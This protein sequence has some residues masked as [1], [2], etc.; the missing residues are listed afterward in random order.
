[1]VVHAQQG[2]SSE[3]YTPIPYLVAARQAMGGIDL[4]PASTAT[5]N[6]NVWATKFYSRADDGLSQPWYGRVWLNPPYSDYRGQ[7][8]EWLGKMLTEYMVGA[9]FQAIALVNLTMAYQPIV[10]EIGRCGRLC[11]VDHRIKFF[12]EHG[13]RQSAPPQSNIFCYLGHRPEHFAEEFS[14]FGVVVKG[15]D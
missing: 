4:D 5:A 6:A 9:V 12:D 8:V 15:V 14:Q 7:A 2:R 13:N 1:M 3:W 11:I 10:Q